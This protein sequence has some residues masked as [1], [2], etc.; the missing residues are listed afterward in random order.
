MT[1][2]GAYAKCN[3]RNLGTCPAAVGRGQN[4]RL[5][6]LHLPQSSGMKK[7]EVFIGARAKVTYLT[8]FPSVLLPSLFFIGAAY[9][10]SWTEHH[11]ECVHAIFSVFK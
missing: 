10:L 6:V 7:Y 11:L 1:Q 2:V 9:P 3:S 8:I 4:L 5:D